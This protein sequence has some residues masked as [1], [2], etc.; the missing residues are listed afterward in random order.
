MQL[1]HYR[2]LAGTVFAGM[3]CIPAERASERLS[4]ENGMSEQVVVG[5]YRG[6]EGE[7][8]W[9]L[10][11]PA[12]YDRAKPPMLMVVLH[13]CTQTADDIARGTQMDRV[14]ESK[15][16]L[17]LYPEQP[18][19]ANPRTC[20]NWFDAAHQHRGAGEPAII[21]GL[22]ADV[23]AQYP[24]DPARVHLVGISAGAGMAGLVAV[25]YPER[26][27][28]LVSASGVA[29]SAA[30]SVGVALSVMQRGAGDALPA[31][32]A[33]IAAMGEHPYAMPVMVIHGDS[34][35]VVSPRNA[36]ETVEQWLG[37][38]RVLRQQGKLP[39]LGAPVATTSQDN[40]Y[41]VR[42]REWRNLAGDAIVSD[43][44]IEEL[45]HAW[46]GG[47]TTGTFTDAKGPDASVLLANFC[48]RH[49]RP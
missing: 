7:R 37:V 30:R 19:S 14:G 45:G 20:W 15:G 25:A 5:R 24:V 23:M 29:W 41:T 8:A 21:A 35:K 47:S 17:V 33:V 32:D 18:A 13:G 22:I 2:R 34:D 49:R 9:R 46:S 4:T 3:L 11:V 10:F 28:S 36:D 42:T 12:S 44:R 39:A 43:V 27:A 48:E 38:H 31:A 1:K 16:F 26:F 40:G 6:A